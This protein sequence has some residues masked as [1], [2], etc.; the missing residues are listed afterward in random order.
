MVH[1]LKELAALVEEL[2]LV[3]ST[4]KQQLAPITRAK[5]SDALF[6]PLWALHACGELTYMQAR[7]SHT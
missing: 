2:G 7:H 6:W 5:G 3:P 1:R 4:T